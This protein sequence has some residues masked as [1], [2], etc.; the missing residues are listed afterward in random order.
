MSGFDVI[1]ILKEDP[2]THSIPVIVVSANVMTKD[3]ERGIERF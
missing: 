3:I 2:A 1:G